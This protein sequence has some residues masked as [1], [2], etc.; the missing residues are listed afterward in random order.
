MLLEGDIFGS[1]KDKDNSF[2]ENGL[3]NMY[4]NWNI[5]KQIG[6]VQ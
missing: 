6:K 2:W 3:K 5:L 1:F 4:G